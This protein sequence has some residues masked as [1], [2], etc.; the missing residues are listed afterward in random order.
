MYVFI[1]KYYDLGLSK[2]LHNFS[3]KFVDL[4]TGWYQQKWVYTQVNI[5]KV[6]Y[7]KY[8]VFKLLISLIN[9]TAS[10]LYVNDCLM[11]D[12]GEVIMY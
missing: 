1:S 2:V 4:C 11:I 8:G 3:S 5:F 7:I 9:V 10:L 6:T 12:L